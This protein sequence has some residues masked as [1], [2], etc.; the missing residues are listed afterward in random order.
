MRVFKTRKV[1]KWARKHS[2]DDGLLVTA[3]N[4]MGVGLIDADY[5]SH[6][7][8]KRIATRGRGKS[9]SV[10]TI[11]A[12]RV[13]ERAYFLYGFEKNERTNIT[14]KEKS[15]YKTLATAVLAF[16]KNDIEERLRAGSLIE[17]EL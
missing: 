7:Y 15:A 5:G 10:R 9:G 11:L 16:N 6:L 2:I 12:L 13:N 4:E 1:A 8:K 3:I 14:D 17:V